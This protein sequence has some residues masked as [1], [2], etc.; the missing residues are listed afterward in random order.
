MESTDPQKLIEAYE[1]ESVDLQQPIDMYEHVSSEESAETSEPEPTMGSGRYQ[2]RQ[3]RAP[4][5]YASQYVL[6]TD[7]DEPECYEEA[8]EDKRKEKWQSAMQDE[9][10]SLHAN[11]TYDLVKLSKGQRTLRNK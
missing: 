9:M 5:Q 1:S 6:L 11:Y 3:R 10:D 8:M 4:S 7:E 2:L